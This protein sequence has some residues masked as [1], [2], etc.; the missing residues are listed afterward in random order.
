[1]ST[2]VLENRPHCADNSVLAT[3]CCRR[4]GLPCSVM[5]V[6]FST[7]CTATWQKRG[8]LVVAF[9]M[10]GNFV[11]M[12][13]PFWVEKAFLEPARW[14]MGPV[15]ESV[16]WG[17]NYQEQVW[18][19]LQWGYGLR[20]CIT[21]W[22]KQKFPRQMF[23]MKRSLCRHNRMVSDISAQKQ[24]LGRRAW[25][26]KISGV[27]QELLEHVALMRTAYAVQPRNKVAPTTRITS[28]HMMFVVKIV[29]K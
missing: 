15:S 10:N 27:L 3:N 8:N 20:C 21:V 11:A 7:L 18:P 26:C 17:E 14:K 2:A 23:V 16:I 1:M 28:L 4:V 12:A 13:W 22:D 25:D 29:S 6:L 19:I 24:F 9:S 5:H